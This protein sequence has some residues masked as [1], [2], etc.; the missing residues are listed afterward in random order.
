[1]GAYSAS[2]TNPYP[3]TDHRVRVDTGS[4]PDGR[5]CSDH[6]ERTDLRRWIDGSLRSHQRRRMNAW[7]HGWHR[8]KQTSH[9]CP[10]QIGRLTD[11]PDG[12]RGQPVDKSLAQKH[13]TRARLLQQRRI[14]AII[15]EADILRT[16]RLQRSYAEIQPIGINALIPNDP[17]IRTFRELLERKRTV[18][19]EE[20][21]ITRQGGVDLPFHSQLRPSVM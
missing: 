17:G 12:T 1:M 14:A 9:P 10:R 6:N 19:L 18:P 7:N 3:F 15:Q 20:P 21:L 11:Q 8:M 5:S 4:C 2:L 16:G 13:Y